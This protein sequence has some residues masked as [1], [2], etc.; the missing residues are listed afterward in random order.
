SEK[1]QVDPEDLVPG[2]I[3]ELSAGNIVPADVR[4]ISSENL[5]VNQSSLTGESLPI[6]KTN[7]YFYM[8][9]KRKIRKVQNLIELENLCFMG[10]HIIS[11][12]A[13]AIVVC[14]GTD[15]YFGSIAKNQFKLN[16]K[17]DSRFDKGV[18][19]VSW[20]LIKFMIIMTPIVMMIYGFINGH[21]YEAF[22]FAI[23]V[24]IGLTPEMLPMIVTANLAKG[25]INMNKKNVLVKQLSS[26]HNLG[27][28]DILCTDKTGTLTEEKMVL[29]HHTDSNG[30]KSDE[31]LKLMYLNGYFHTAYKN[32]I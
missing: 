25:S 2:D 22:L 23:A 27:A 14:T 6:E 19:K 21:W 12:T 26:I 30:E 13:K 29:V 9:K 20:L 16:K 1:V 4:I 10:T 7:Q 15:T 32:E 8:Y 3:I 28:M 17:S 24:A 18:S 5:L 31:V 11:G